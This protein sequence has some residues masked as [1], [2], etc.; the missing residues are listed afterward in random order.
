M[1]TAT[2]KSGSGLLAIWF[3]AIVGAGFL[4]GVI[5]NTKS[6]ER[7]G[8]LF[9]VTFEPAQRVTFVDIVVLLDGVAYKAHKTK[10]TPWDIVVQMKRGQTAT[11]KATQSV[12]APLSCAVNGQVQETRAFPGTVT[13]IHKRA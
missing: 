8:V 11:L 3:M 6:D 1:T 9:T 4:Y 2:K 12:P 13:C 10:K 7:S 5:K